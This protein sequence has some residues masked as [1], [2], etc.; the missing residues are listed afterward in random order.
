[1]I[2]GCNDKIV[3][4]FEVIWYVYTNVSEEVVASFFRKEAKLRESKYT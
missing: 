1:M 4:I 3:V 2:S